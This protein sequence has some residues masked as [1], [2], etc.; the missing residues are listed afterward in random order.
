MVVFF[1]LNKSVGCMRESVTAMFCMLCT[2]FIIHVLRYSLSI[3]ASHFT[4]VCSLLK[5]PELILFVEI[6]FRRKN[7]LFALGARPSDISNEGT[8]QAMNRRSHFPET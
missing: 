7:R 2:A 4:N 8:N 6:L 3:L 5:F 1:V